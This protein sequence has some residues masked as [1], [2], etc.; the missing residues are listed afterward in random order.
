MR[1]DDDL[2]PGTDLPG[3]MA[4]ARWCWSRGSA[5]CVRWRRW[6]TSRAPARLGGCRHR[7]DRRLEELRE[8]PDPVRPE[9]PRPP[10]RRPVRRRRGGRC[11]AGF[12][13]AGLGTDLDR[14]AM[15]AAGFYVCVADLEDELIRALG[16]DAVERVVVAAGELRL[17]AHLPEATAPGGASRSTSSCGASW[18]PTAAGT[19]G[20]RRYW[21]RRSTSTAS[22]GRSTGSLPMSDGSD[23]PGSDGSAPARR[24]AFH[25]GAVRRRRRRRR[26]RPGP[27]DRACRH[28]RRDRDRRVAWEGRG[29]IPD[30]G[31]NG[32]RC[33]A[34]AAEPGTRCATAPRASRARSR[35]GPSSGPTRMPCS[36]VW[37]GRG[38]RRRPRTR[39]SR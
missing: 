33:P 14:A 25:P 39:T 19:S 4:S 36:R 27:A 22:P 2:E 7:V 23:R 31:R 6:R 12:E 18:A 30:R 5:I 37:C 13:S 34:P 11:P 17:V 16:S 35:T 38:H 9:W 20:M 29:R 1:T 10:T 15:E 28:R 24:P 3:G 21:W 26:H 8:V 32:G